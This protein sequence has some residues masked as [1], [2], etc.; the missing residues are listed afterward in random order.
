MKFRPAKSY[1][2]LRPRRGAVVML[3]PYRPVPGELNVYPLAY[4]GP[5]DEINFLPS[6]PTFEAV[7]TSTTTTGGGGAGFDLSAWVPVVGGVFQLVGD[8]VGRR[9]QA[10]TPQQ[11]VVYVQKPASSNFGMWALGIG[12]VAVAAGVVYWALKED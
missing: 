11:Q 5:E 2:A 12:G 8:L 3:H 4:S 6:T 7:P 9:R 1:G 10:Q